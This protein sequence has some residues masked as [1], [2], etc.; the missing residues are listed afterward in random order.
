MQVVQPWLIRRELSWFWAYL[1]LLP[2]PL[3]AAVFCEQVGGSRTGRE[4]GRRSWRLAG[5]LDAAAGE[6][7]MPGGRGQ[8]G[9]GGWCGVF[10]GGVLAFLSGGDQPRRPG[11]EERGSQP[12]LGPRGAGRCPGDKMIDGVPQSGVRPLSLTGNLLEVAGR[13]GATRA[14][15]FPAVAAACAEVIAGGALLGLV[16]RRAGG[17][18]AVAAGV[19]VTFMPGLS[20]SSSRILLRVWRPASSRA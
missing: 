13:A 16:D 19:R 7:I 14:G 18:A 20:R 6:R 12:Y 8:E 5:V 11:R 10:T 3:I 2:A 15:V 17:Q 9:P 4:P 1:N